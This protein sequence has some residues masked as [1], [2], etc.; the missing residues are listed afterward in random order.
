MF[1]EIL[2]LVVDVA[3]IYL[4]DF[5]LG[6]RFMKYGTQVMKYLTYDQFSRTEM[7]NPMCT[8]F[9]TVTS[10]TFHSVGTAAGEQKFN[11]LCV[12]SLN[13]I[14]EKVYLLLW[15][16]LFSLTILTCI[17]LIFRLAIIIIHPLRYILIIIKTRGF[18]NSDLNTCKN[19]LEHCYLGDW[20]VLYQL[21][22]NSNTY[23]FRYL[24]R[25]LEKSF[26]SQ[27]KSNRGGSFPKYSEEG[28][29]RKVFVT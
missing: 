17:H 6:G 22:K 14:N 4:T 21:S 28:K 15:F 2:N 8:V 9:P 20:F 18:T 19:V 5:F 24:L 27:A 23:F 10:C 7:P 26:V 13:I 16:W 29:K 1:C 11:S 25:H 3:N 12:L